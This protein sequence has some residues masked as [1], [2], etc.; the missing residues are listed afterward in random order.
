MRRTINVK[1]SSLW[2]GLLLIAVILIL[3]WASF[4]GGGTSIFEPKDKFI[5][6]FP[7]VN[8]LVTGAPVW[9]AGVEVGN[10]VGME[11]VNLDP[12]RRVK[13]TCRAKESV[14]YMLT[15]DTKVQLGTIGFL[16]DKYV[17]ILP[18]SKGLPLIKP[19]DVIPS[20]QAPSAEALFSS[21]T[22]TFED[23]GTLAKNLDTLLE[24][25]NRGEGTLGQFATDK[26]LY[27][28]MT[29]LL[30]NLTALTADL[31]KNQERVIGS[32][33]RMSH[34]IGD[35]SDQITE[36][37]GTIGKLMNNP[38]LYNN[39]AAT[40]AQL[41]TIMTKINDA[42][43]SMGMMVNDTTLYV[44]LTNLLVRARTLMDNIEQNPRR[45]FKFSV[46]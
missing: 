34:S 8:G 19:G 39:L 22:E 17:E 9:L 46:F 32:V 27:T 26:Q 24:R 16:G 30:A 3:L 41:D 28:H 12:K 25:M 37:R 43:G 33:E 18:G 45:Y 10:V 36:D 20:V 4:S 11:F 5:C 7:N 13:L 38:D 23:F 21:G 1:W 14:W 15:E 31:Q 2:V 29:R 6:Y 42:K 40:S 35:L 44:E